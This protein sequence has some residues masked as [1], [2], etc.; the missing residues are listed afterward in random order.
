MKI[1]VYSL[2]HGDI[3]GNYTLTY[4]GE[5]M[6]ENNVLGIISQSKRK[7]K[8]S[9]KMFI[10]MTDEDTFYVCRTNKSWKAYRLGEIN[11]ERD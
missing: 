9:G 5:K 3:Y 7:F 6:T 8:I 10:V 2:L 4:E 1:K 11:A